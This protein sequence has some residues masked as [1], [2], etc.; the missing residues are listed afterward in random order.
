MSKKEHMKKMIEEEN[1]DRPQ[2]SVEFLQYVQ[3][4]QTKVENHRGRVHKLSKVMMVVGICGMGYMAYKHMTHSSGRHHQNRDH[5]YSG[6]GHRL[7][8]SNEASVEDDGQTAMF[9]AMSFAIWGL[10]VSKAKSGLEAATK[11]DEKSVGSI[12][13]RIGTFTALI[14]VASVCQLM[15]QPKSVETITEAAKTPMKLQAGN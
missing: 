1:L 9:K 4:H 14:V 6:N 13:K 2:D 3:K 11:T 15:S 8:A 12:V 10:I 7:G 5:H